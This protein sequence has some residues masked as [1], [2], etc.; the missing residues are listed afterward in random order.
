MK[1]IIFI[2]IVTLF[3]SCN[4][5][6][7]D[8]Y[9]ALNLS[10]VA[11]YF[12]IVD[13]DGNDLFFGEGAIY[14]PH[15]VKF[16]VGQG[17]PQLAGVN[18]DK[19][20]QYFSLGTIGG[21]TFV[22]YAEFIPDKIDTIKTESHFTGWHEHPEGCRHHAIYKYNLFFNDVQICIECSEEIFKIEMR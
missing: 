6:K 13:G 14:D 19:S 5:G 15:N 4:N 3:N 16:T 17:D 18:V 22:F 20:E 9:S 1:T 10:P 7:C 12:S 21:E 11:L 8:N 2:I